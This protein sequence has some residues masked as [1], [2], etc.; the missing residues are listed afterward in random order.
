MPAAN[1]YQLG[2]SLSDVKIIPG[3]VVSHDDP[4]NM[5]RVKAFVPGLFDTKTMS[6]DAM[7]W[8]YPLCMN[9]FQSFSLQNS[10][11]KIWVIILPNNPYGYFY[12][13]FFE[14]FSGTKANIDGETD[15]LLSR[16]T[17]L[18][19]ASVH[20][21]SS[22]GIMAKLGN[23]QMNIAPNGQASLQSTGA[24]VK[25]DQGRVHIGA[26]DDEGEPMVMGDKL[27]T[28]L[29]NLQ[30]GLDKVSQKAMGHPITMP[31]GQ[32][33][34]NVISTLSEDISNI[35]STSCRLTK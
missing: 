1:K 12:L 31:I 21:N 13:P 22:D 34:L 11:T 23:A 24:E 26:S 16:Q 32:E 29:N 2:I 25:I 5:Q 6:I 4:K 14:L 15:I 8:I 30:T 20:Y 27:T 28:L 3:V 35:N 33:L 9:G 18:G 10:N 17:S 19:Q 7:P